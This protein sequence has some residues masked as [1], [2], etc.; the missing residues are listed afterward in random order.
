MTVSF[1][2]NRDSVFENHVM[3]KKNTYDN[4]LTISNNIVR[5]CGNGTVAYLAARLAKEEMVQKARLV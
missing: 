4:K 2:Q 1:E 5:E 3:R